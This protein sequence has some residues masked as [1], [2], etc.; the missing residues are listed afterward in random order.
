VVFYSYWVPLLTTS[1]I[2]VRD[3]QLADLLVGKSPE[4]SVYIFRDFRF[5][6]QLFK[7][8][9]RAAIF[10]NSKLG[11][12]VRYVYGSPTVNIELKLIIFYPA[13]RLRNRVSL[14]S[15]DCILNIYYFDACK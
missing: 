11:H 13:S 12:P 6:S 14:L 4:F 7:Y 1:E 9:K 2:G 15:F 10:P 8:F 3:P 5:S